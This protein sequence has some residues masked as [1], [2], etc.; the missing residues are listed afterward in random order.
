MK[1]LALKLIGLLIFAGFTLSA[2]EKVTLKIT[3]NSAA[4]CG[5]EVTIKAGKVPLGKGLTDSE[6][7]VTFEN[8][9]LVTK[10]INVY[11]YKK[12]KNGEKKWSM[13]G[14]VILNEDNHAEITM[15]KFINDAAKDSGLSVSMLA[16]AWGLTFNCD[17]TQETK[18]EGDNNGGGMNLNDL[19]GK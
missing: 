9:K 16:G 5:H 19:F 11:G 10:E 17:G 3:Y 7:H 8:I 14:H 2:Q 6:G 4:V 1:T 15:E 12:T 13:E 18:T